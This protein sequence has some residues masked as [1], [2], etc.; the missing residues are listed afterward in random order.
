MF[1]K[2]IMFGILE[3]VVLRLINIKKTIIGDSVITCDEILDTSETVSTHF[4]DK[5]KTN[6]MIIT[7]FSTRFY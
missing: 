4:E 6:E 5:K 2:T 7:V 1:E 3:H